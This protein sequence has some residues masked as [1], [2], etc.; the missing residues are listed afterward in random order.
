[1]VGQNLGHYRIEKKLGAGGM[2]IVYGARDT[3]L[4]RLVAIKVLRPDSLGSPERKRRFVQ[5]AKSASALNHPN[6]I[7]VFDI[8]N[9]GGT[10]YIAMEFVAGKPLDRL[11]KQHPFS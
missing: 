4:D 6:I 7:T 5:E 1:M 3:H 10:D 11:L 9:D 8:N 2:G